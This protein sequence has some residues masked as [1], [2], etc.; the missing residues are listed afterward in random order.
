MRSLIQSALICMLCSQAAPGHAEMFFTRINADIVYAGDHLQNGAG[1]NTKR[2]I[3]A[4]GD[5]FAD[6]SRIQ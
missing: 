3:R 4:H 2:E 5:G 6:P 1:F